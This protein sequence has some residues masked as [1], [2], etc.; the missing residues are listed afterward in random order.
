MIGTMLRFGINCFRNLIEK[1]FDEVHE[2]IADS[3]MDPQVEIVV[4]RPIGP[5][6]SGAV[7][8]HG[9]KSYLSIRKDIRRPSVTITSPSSPDPN[10]RTSRFGPVDQ[11]KMQLKIWVGLFTCIKLCLVIGCF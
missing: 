5:R 3:K 4:S 8:P 1:T 9:S 2:V 10:S 6:N 11:G 7:G